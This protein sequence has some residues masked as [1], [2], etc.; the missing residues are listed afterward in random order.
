MGTRTK[1]VRSDHNRS[2]KLFP[3]ACDVSRMPE[4][5]NC[6]LFA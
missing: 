3:I 2:R 5:D 1:V 6:E 4:I